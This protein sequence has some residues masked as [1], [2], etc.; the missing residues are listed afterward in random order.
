MPLSIIFLVP[1]LLIASWTDFRNRQIYNSLLLPSLVC[2]L[3]MHTAASGL[4]GLKLSL[5]GAFTGFALLIVPYLLGGMGA[6]DVKLLMVIGAFGGTK[7]VIYSFLIGAVAGGIISLFL[8][9]YSQLEKKDIT[10]LPYGIP[11]STGT[12]VSIF[13]IYWR[14]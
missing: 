10:T 5:F 2:A 6:A 14:F 8:L 7:F 13:L 11:L 12:I 3:L 9:I 1:V 4:A